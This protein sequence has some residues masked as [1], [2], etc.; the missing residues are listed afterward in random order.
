MAMR[1][2]LEK[3]VMALILL[4]GWSGL[5]CWAGSTEAAQEQL[6]DL[7]LEELMEIDINTVYSASK[8]AQ[9]V[10]EAPSSVTVITADEVRKYGYRTLT[11]VLRSVPGFYI[12]YDRNYHYLGIRGFRRPGDYS[13]RI[14]LLVDGHRINENVGDSPALGTDFILDV[15]LI[16]RVEIIRGP[17]SSLYGSNALLAVINV[18][19]KTGDRIGGLELSGEVASHDTTKG[20]ITYGDTLDNG[21]EILVSGTRYE[22]EGQELYFA[23]FDDPATANG[24]VRND[25]N[26]FDNLVANVRWGDMTLLLAHT[27]REKGVPTASWDTVFG[28]PR[29]R[30]WDDTTLVGLTYARELSRTWTLKGRAA[31]THYNCDARWATDYAEAG[32]D[33]NIVV[34]KEYWKGRWWEGEFQVV[35]QPVAGH[36][37]TAGSEF[38]YNVRQDQ[39]NWDEEVYLDDSRHSHNWGL[40]VQDEF[41]VLDGTTIVG[42]LRYDKY[43]RLG[44][45]T[46]PRLALIQ[47]LGADTT[48][49]LL[50]GKAF[51]V[52]NVYE[53]YYHDG[54]ATAKAAQDLDPEAIATYEVVLEH[55]FT[56]HWRGTVSGF[57]Y[58]MEDLIAQEIDPADGLEVFRNLD[59]VKARGLELTLDGR[60]DSGLRARTSY[61]YVDAEDN[62]TGATLVNSPQHLAKLNL[63][64]P[65]VE[66]TLFAGLEVQY[67]SKSKTLTG[68]DADDF[69]LTNLTLTYTS[70]S[71][72]LELSAGLYNL[73]DIEYGYPAFGE[74]EQDVIDQ[75]GRTFGVKLTY[76]F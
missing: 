7:S 3:T 9:K 39:A 75:D 18:I 29:T 51:R 42:G 45:T 8:H 62:A 31:Y 53:L 34:N 21:L 5:P 19:T 61:S 46:N 55:A 23:E 65:V 60:W 73:F 22:S 43:D 56:P 63:I 68:D 6:F 36:T 47:D 72:K 2:V 24:L 25:D 58:V 76:R 17:G 11:E 74:H 28:D 14:L 4:S 10:S 67:N 37:L 12:N 16:D 44:G 35:G 1:S 41:E 50:Y 59:E 26:Q 13:T 38:R 57:Y 49:K 54:E 30:S 40:Y 15:D 33:P 64:A 71:R 48:L 70:P 69:F 20:R 66:D 32:E 52:P 27:A